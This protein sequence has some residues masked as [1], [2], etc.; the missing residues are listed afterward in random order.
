MKTAGR[1]ADFAAIGQCTFSAVDPERFPAVGMAY[2]ALKAGGAA[3]CMLNAANEE[4]NAGFRAGRIGFLQ[5][6]EIVTETLQRMGDQGAD[7]LEQVYAA[8]AAAR[9]TAQEIME[10]L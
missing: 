6:G 5:I 9:R 4:A 1:Q 7:T 8:D 2:E 10:K 3:A